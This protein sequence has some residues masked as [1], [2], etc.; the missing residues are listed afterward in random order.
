M[1]VFLF[2]EHL[3]VFKGL[4]LYMRMDRIA[5]DFPSHFLNQG[6]LLLFSQVYL[7]TKESIPSCH[8]HSRK[9]FCCTIPN[10]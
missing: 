1:D 2:G 7:P 5:V 8:H 10:F 6:L 9:C 4:V 3:W